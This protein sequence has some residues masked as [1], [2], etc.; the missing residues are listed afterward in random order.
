MKKHWLTLLFLLSLTVPMF[1]S[2]AFSAAPLTTIFIQPDGTINPSN[3]PIQ[4][5]GDVYTLTGNVSDPI[6]IQKSNITLDGAGYSVVGPLTLEEINSEPPLGL[7][8]NTTLPPYII[9]LDCD[10][11]VD[12]LTIKNLNV[13]NFNVGVYLRT[14]HNILIGNAVSQNTVGILLSGSSNTVTKNYIFDNKMGLFFGFAQVNGSAS[15]IPSDI[16]ISQNSFINNT[17]QLT[18]CVCKVYNFS[19]PIH[20]WDNGTVGNYWSNYNG[21]D[22]DHDGI[23]DTYYRIDVLNQDRYPL[24]VSPAELP[25][26]AP[27]FQFDTV[28][29]GVA[30][31]VIAVAAILVYWRYRKK[32]QG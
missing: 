5:N 28:A 24:I 7:G 25:F 4:R 32:N 12:G 9:G 1:V 21:T 2:T 26:P 13:D 17:Q 11:T 27:K 14:T 16:D 22:A 20:S 18:G 29:I 23:G 8:P 3:V 6:L 31:V 19:E 30:L 10:K 15:N